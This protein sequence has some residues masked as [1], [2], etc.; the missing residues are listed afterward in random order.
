MA[1]RFASI[2][3]AKSANIYEVNIRQY[4]REGTFAAFQQHLPRLRGMGVEILW[5]MPITPISV[6]KRLGTL[7][8][9]Y[10]C[11]S[12]TTINPEYGNLDDFKGLVNKAHELGFKLII[13]WVANHTGYDHHWATE[14]PDWYVKNEKGEFYDRNGWNDV[15][16]LNYYNAEMR[17]ALIDAMRFWVRDC[18]IDGFRCDMAHLVPLDFW[19]EARAQCEKLKPLFWL[20]ECDVEAYHEVFDVSYAWEWMHVSEKLFKGTAS[21]QHF[22]DVLHK[23]GA[24]PAGASKLYFTTNHDENSWNGTEYEKYDSGAKTLAVFCVTW[25]G[26]PLLY[27]GQELPNLRRLSFFEKDFI[28]WQENLALHQFYKT[29]FSLKKQ[30]KA[31]HYNDNL[32]ELPTGFDDKV[33]AYL[34]VTGTSKVL[35]LLNLSGAE[36]LK[37]SIKHQNLAGTYTNQFSGLTY[38]LK[39]EEQF[40]LQAWEYIVLATE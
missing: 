25:P 24:Y 32:A 10:A 11:S 18:G 29:L 28:D 40:E 19:V 38:S 21:L 3:W 27:S 31:L 36:R 33:L 8:S 20:A 9:Y 34:R 2:D 26:T 4:T 15:I 7:G 39:G 12:Y 35:V 30:N 1:T 22:K 6:K 37:F 5:L 16:D 14:H 13:D 17:L 23:Y